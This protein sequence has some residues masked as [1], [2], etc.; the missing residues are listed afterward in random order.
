MYQ[1]QESNG[2]RWYGYS[3]ISNL[4][5]KYLRSLS[6]IDKDVYDVLCFH[7]DKQAIAWP[8]I[9]RLA[10]LCG[11]S[12]RTINR[13][14]KHLESLGMIHRKRRFKKSTIYTIHGIALENSD[15]VE[16]Q[17]Q[18]G[19]YIPPEGITTENGVYSDT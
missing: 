6:E 16:S 17:Y 10:T 19:V 15:S 3:R 14:L 11:R 7:A 12:T 8:T 5:I 13:A 18:R 4:K 1:G 9:T 2:E